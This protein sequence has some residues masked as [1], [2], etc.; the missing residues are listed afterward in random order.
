M[1]C[2]C[3]CSCSGDCNLCLYVNKLNKKNLCSLSGVC[4]CVLI[5]KNYNKGKKF[6][7]L[8]A[9]LYTLTHINTLFS[10]QS[11]YYKVIH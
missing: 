6:T 1:C 4:V 11:I 10:P 5:N 8:H 2:S 9:H 3:S 7:F